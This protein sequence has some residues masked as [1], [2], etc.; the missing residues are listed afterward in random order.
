MTGWQRFFLLIVCM[1]ATLILWP[2]YDQAGWSFVLMAG[3]LWTCV[4]IMLSV[5]SGIF[6]IYK[7]EFL[8]RFISIL[9]LGALIACLLYY[10]P[11]KN[12][13]T[14]FSR[15]KAGKWPTTQ[16]VQTGLERLT[17][18]VD[19]LRR[20]MHKEGKSI[21][22]KIDEASEVVEDFEKTAKEKKEAFDALAD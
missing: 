3:I 12:A 16:D 13:E 22:Q 8:N 14:P 10:F 5:L 9:F 7:F 4:I 11:L 20:N 17:I 2:Q 19:F 21:Q 1:A 18:D 15:M 6:G